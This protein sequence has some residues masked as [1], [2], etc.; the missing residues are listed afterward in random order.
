[1]TRPSLPIFG[2]AGSATLAPPPASQQAQPGQTR[3]ELAIT[4]MHCASCVG[5]VQDALAAEPG[6]SQAAVNLLTNSAVVSFDPARTSARALTERVAAVGYG[7]NLPDTSAGALANAERQDSARTAEITDFGV[8]AAVSVAVGA[9]TMLLP[10]SPMDQPFAAAAVAQFGATTVVMA[11]AGRHFYLRA[12]KALRHGTADMNTLVSVGTLAAWAWSVVAMAAPHRMMSNGVAPALY[13]EA[14]SFIIGFILVGNALD[15]RAKGQTVRA[16]RTLLD[17]APPVAVIVEGDRQREV[18]VGDVRAGDVVLV[19]PGARIPVDGAIVDGTSAVDEAMVTGEPMPVARTTGHRVIGG[20]V[21]GSGVLRVRATDVGEASVLARIVAMMRNA[22][23]ERAPVEALV[24]RIAA[25]FVPVVLVLAALTAVTWLVLLGG[26]GIARALSASVA[27]LIIAC[28][29]AMGLAVPAAVMVA[30]GRAAQFGV[31]VKGGRGLE[32][33]ARVTV[34][35]VD[36]T[37]TLTAGKPAVASFQLATG[38]MV[39]EAEVLDL[40]AAVERVSEHPLAGAIVRYADWRGAASLVATQFSATAGQGA[41]AM[42]G[43]RAVLV[44]NAAFLDDWGISR[45]AGDAAAAL[46][47]ASGASTVFAAVDGR[48]AAIIGVRDL[49]RP[50][51]AA[52]VRRIEALGIRVI[53]LTGDQ[54]EAAAAVARDVGIGDVRAGLTPEAKLEAIVT[55]QHKGDVVAMVGDGINDAPALARADVGIAVGTGADVAIEASDV[56]LMRPGVDAVADALQLSRMAMRIIHQNLFWAFAYNVVGIA[57]AAGVFFPWTGA[58]LS[59]II[60]SAAM[61][62]SSVSVVSNSLRLRRFTPG[63]A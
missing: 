17:L 47:G 54:A 52:A 55:L 8:K 62:A 6:V 23:A 9:G 43:S 3:V 36:K 58:M 32:R 30:T 57:V 22:Q 26:E 2:A 50:T 48:L 5:R 24:D 60:A 21:N 35:A 20:T 7:A 44:G 41:S 10:M 56:T 40:V 63:S 18:P 49:P 14:V 38:A 39:T 42:V 59:P 28:P 61:A 4:G 46:A 11:W 45:I 19:R 31:L 12:W 15:A 27:V 13:F 25:V 53:M 16:L 37:G 34:V 1:M 29:C 33:T 51:S